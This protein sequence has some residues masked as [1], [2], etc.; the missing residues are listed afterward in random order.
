MVGMGTMEI[1]ILLT[2]FFSSGGPLSLPLSTPPLPPDPLLER[3]AP[4][5]CLAYLEL[6]GLAAPQADAD[7]PTER[8]LADPE[9]QEFLAA[10]G[11]QAARLF[12]EAA[13]L[14]P[15]GNDASATLIEAALTR[16]LAIS[17]ERFRPPSP[18]G[19]PELAASLLM[20]LG[21]REAAI[22]GAVAVLVDNTFGGGAPA[23]AP[24][25]VRIAGTQ[26]QQ[27][28]TPVGPLS[29]GFHDE[30]F[31]ITIGPDTLESLLKRL[32]DDG[33]ES[34]A[35]KGDIVKRF[36][37]TRRSTLTYLNLKKALRLVMSLPAAERSPLS[38][39]LEAAGVADLEVVGGVTG[40]SESG[41]VSSLWI[42]CA[43]T[44]HGLLA[45]P[46]T[47][48]NRSV[49]ARLPSEAVLAQSWSLDLSA[50]LAAGLD[51]VAAGDPQAAA[52]IRGQLEQ[53]RAIAGLDLDAHL[54]A[55][56]GP[57]W[58]VVSVPA[59]GGLLP[60]FALVAGVR[61]R[62]TFAR[63][64]KAL[65]GILRNAAAAGSLPVSVR[66]IPYRDQ[67]LFCLEAATA[68][69][70]I[71]I[72]PSWCLTDDRLI[73]TISPQFLKTLLVRDPGDPGL[74]KLPEVKA[75]M[76]GGEPAF[77][78]VVD[79]T[80]LLGTLCGLYEMAVPLARTA[81]RQQGLDV[82]LPQ[83]PP[84][85]AIMPYARPSV[86]LIRHEDD[87][88]LI[89]STGT[90]PL[91]PLTAGGGLLGV[92]PAA[93]PVMVGLLLPAVQSARE[94]ARRA[95]T[96][97]Q[98]RQVMLAMLT[99]ESVRRTLPPQAICDDDGKPLL[100][101]RVAILPYL[102]EEGLH[103]QFRLD[104]PWD[105]DHNLKLVEQM[106][107]VY[108]DPTAPAEQAARGLTTVQVMTGPNTPFAV[109]AKGLQFRAIRDGTSKTVAIVEAM[110][111]KA[112]PWTKPQDLSFDPD[113]PLAGVGNPWRAGKGFLIGFFDGSVRL[114]D[115]EIDRATFKALV[116]P[117]GDEPVP[118]A[119]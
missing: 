8:M 105:S 53:F 71:P 58:S 6:A 99:Y 38:A 104:E 34:P 54:L 33:R 51:V 20:R 98:F 40:M 50:M 21:D 69:M 17:I 25:T 45:K 3:A 35:W 112:V 5:E 93:T 94:A 80:T 70:P 114:I 66:E 101:W 76:A 115:P 79:P 22:R 118:V 9:M 85:S 16:P 63:T 117:A 96:Q 109:P 60:G 97:N 83:L 7:N 36:P 67:T 90:I 49:L 108:A 27:V 55:P 10:L 47:G 91:G 87:G 31:I 59:P 30:S 46:A 41:V 77:L 26:W 102:D 62:A 84:A 61:D 13:A 81:G 89:E 44:P 86:S 23:G 1:L 12:R 57:D 42:G 4:A 111:D 119:P 19:P 48:V 107:A 95:Q 78:G 39:V 43:E 116:T 56:L 28:A 14:P 72:T 113:R 92:S 64:H 15:E 11:S 106:P 103:N 110:P 24:R 2:L 82:D 29:W 73:V 32:A 88:I 37:V 52:E 75:A 65:L 18:Q 100:S 68:E 74:G